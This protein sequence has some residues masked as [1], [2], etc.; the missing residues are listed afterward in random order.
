M[1][2]SKLRRALLLVAC[3]VLLVSLSVGATLA[4][5]T[6]TTQEVVNTFTVGSVVIDLDEAKVDEYGNIVSGEDAGR[7]R[8][9]TYKLLP[10]HTYVKDPTVHVQAGS[11]PSYIRILVTISDLTDLKA[12]CG[13]AEGETFLPQNFVGG[14]DSAKW[15]CESMKVEDNK[16]ILEFRYYTIVDASKATA[17]VDLEALFTTIKVPATATNAQISKLSDMS[18]NIIAHAMQAD[19][20]ENANAAWAAWGN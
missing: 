1:K 13:V 8:A 6:Y 2:N 18:I 15:P 10:G 3:A 12:A 11:E 20:F 5:L 17:N 14:W 19:G 7:V 16:C 9:N 4:Y